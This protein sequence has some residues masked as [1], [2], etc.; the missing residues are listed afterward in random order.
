MHVE[1]MGLA[2]SVF[3]FFLKTDMIAEQS[4][5]LLWHL[6]ENLSI[7]V[8]YLIFHEF[9]HRA[10]IYLLLYHQILILI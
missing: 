2:S 8:F 9:Y 3:A 6:Q 7:L 10:I 1:S 4:V 5:N